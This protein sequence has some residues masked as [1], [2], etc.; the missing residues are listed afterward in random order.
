MTNDIVVGVEKIE[1][2]ISNGYAVPST[3]VV[4][5][6]IEDGSVSYTSNKDNSTPIIP[7]DKDLPIIVLYTPA[8]ADTFNFAALEISEQNLAMLMGIV[9]DPSTSLITVLATKKHANLWIRLTTRPQFGVKKIFVFPNTVCDVAYKNNFTK[10]ALVSIAIT[11]SI[12][13]YTD[14]NNNVAA[15]TIQKV[16]ADGS[17]INGTPSFDTTLDFTSAASVTL[18][19]ITGTIAATSSVVKFKFNQ[20]SSPVGTPENMVLHLSGDDVISVDFPSDYSGEVWEYIDAS[21]V[22]YTGTFTNGTI[23]IS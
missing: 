12:L 21:S 22:V 11:A 10:N 13:A 17:S 20:I 4:V 7:E 5:N 8:D 18:H 16:N 6:N 15:Y 9:F 2:G 1:I 23:N 3:I 14:A 19:G